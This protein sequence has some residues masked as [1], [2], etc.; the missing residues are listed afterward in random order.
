MS[1]VARRWA[2]RT[3]DEPALCDV[4]STLT[5]SQLD[6][7]LNRGTN[8]LLGLGLDPARDSVAICAE[9]S[10]EVVIGHLCGALAGI[11]TVPVNDRLTAAELAYIL[12]DAG[13]VVVLAGPETLSVA[14]A[15]ARLVGEV[16]VIAWRAGGD[17]GLTWEG[18][19]TS[20]AD[21]EPP[22]DMPPRPYLHYTSGTTGKPKAVHT[23]PTI[24]QGEA[25]VRE[26]IA[27][28]ATNAMAAGAASLVVSPLYHGAGLHYIKTLAAGA[29]LVVLGRFAPE[30]T[31]AAIQEHRITATTMVPTHFTRLLALPAEV[32]ERYD[33]SSLRMVMHTG[34]ACPADVKRRM[35]DWFGPVLVEVY[36]ATESGGATM[37]T[38]AE[39]LE[40]PGSVG[41][42]MAPFEILAVG[43]D[44]RP[45]APGEVGELYLRDTTGHG[46]VY[47]QDPVKT[48]QVHLAPGV[49]TLG[50]VGYVDDQ[51]YVFITDRVVDMV[52]SGGVN[53]YPAEA[54]QVLLT[55]PQVADVACIGVP[56]HEL[57]EEL[58]ALVI[59][60]DPADPP[61]PEVLIESCRGRLAV[62]KC[63]RSV[64]LVTDIGRTAL[65]K[66]DKRA[67]RAPYWPT[68]RTVG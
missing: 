48:G 64:D 7:V 12:G 39:W 67:L 44:G 8:A 38:S 18:I 23:P 2:A 33:L 30:P 9:N 65:G 42:A 32:R 63:P 14:R 46:I 61:D 56:H 49:F 55:H 34:A 26:H 16:R 57:G 47:R 50:D 43:P 24:Y 19:L 54:E 25:T 15:A 68:E 22:S 37:I 29:K 53:I 28:S 60:R 5:W 3:P 21:V 40:R 41:R 11:S 62:Y 35:I 1:E 4:R 31:L 45:V 52:V 17:R 27:A 20:G 59:P 36:G 58:K 10:V 13:S 66:V 51:G 6:S